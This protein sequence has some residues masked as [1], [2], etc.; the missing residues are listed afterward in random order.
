LERQ[1]KIFSAKLVY[2]KSREPRR[3]SCDTDKK[4]IFQTTILEVPSH[5][6]GVISAYFPNGNRCTY[7][8]L[9]KLLKK[10][11]KNAIVGGDLNANSDL[12]KDGY[13]TNNS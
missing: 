12:W 7:E 5:E 3:R 2:E 1:K 4:I 6:I 9:E 13:Q 10:T 11:G 8:E